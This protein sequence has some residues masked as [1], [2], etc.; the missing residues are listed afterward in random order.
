[1]DTY[2]IETTNRIKVTSQDIDDIMSTA[3]EGG[4]NYWCCKAE[5]VGKRLGEYASDQISRGGTL[6]L[7]DAESSDSWPLNLETLLAGLTMAV[8]GDWYSDY[9]WYGNGELDTSQIDAEVADV[10]VQL[11]LFEDI[12][13][14]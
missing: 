7:H 1:M 12:I 13:F 4:I 10:I 14:G 2:N 3:L 6:I 5:V 9:E 11:A 8:E